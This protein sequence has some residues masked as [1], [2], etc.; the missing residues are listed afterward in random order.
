MYHV[1]LNTHT[2]NYTI[3][4]I[5]FCTKLIVIHNLGFSSSILLRSFSSCHSKSKGF[6]FVLFFLVVWFGFGFFA[7]CTYRVTVFHFYHLSKVFDTFINGP[8]LLIMSL[9]FIISF[10]VR[11]HRP[12]FVL[13]VFPESRGSWTCSSVWKTLVCGWMKLAYAFRASLVAQMVKHLPALQEI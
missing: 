3:K 1:I 6:C 9:S 12:S 10:P 8:I 2:H 13:I 11:R 5:H 4:Y 7:L